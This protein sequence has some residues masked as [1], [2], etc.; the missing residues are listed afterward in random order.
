MSEHTPSRSGSAR[1][2]I[3]EG[4]G[5]GI[6]AFRLDPLR[7]AR[8]LRRQQPASPTRP[9]WRSM[10]AQ[11]F[12]YAVNELKSYQDQPTGTVSAFA[13]D[14]GDGRADVPEQAA[15]PW[16]R[17][18]PCRCRRQGRARLRRQFHERQRL[19]AAGA[20]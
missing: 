10:P 16:H 4:K 15:D 19:R 7:R 8:A 11:R 20:R 12:L 9:I 14:A 5:E 1:D 13:V 2:K 17:S 18:L 6:Y 3:L